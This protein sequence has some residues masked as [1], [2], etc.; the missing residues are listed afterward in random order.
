MQYAVGLIGILP[1]WT[2]M[3][4][5]RSGCIV[6]TTGMTNFTR[7]SSGNKIAN[8]NFLYNDIV[9]ALK[10]PQTLAYIVFCNAGLP[11]SVK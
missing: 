9:H 7:N 10:I 5:D 11:N 3:T 1:E 4:K 6:S 8:V 2:E